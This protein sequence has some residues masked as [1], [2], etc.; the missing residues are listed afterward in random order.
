MK[1]QLSDG[2]ELDIPENT[3]PRC[4]LDEDRTCDLVLA[5]IQ[6]YAKPSEIDMPVNWGCPV[7]H[8]V[9][10]V[11]IDNPDYVADDSDKAD[12]DGDG[13]PAGRCYRCDGRV[14]TVCTLNTKGYNDIPMILNGC[15]YCIEFYVGPYEGSNNMPIEVAVEAI[16]LKRRYGATTAGVLHMI[17]TYADIVLTKMLAN[18]IDLWIKQAASGIL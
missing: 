14:E 9:Q 10:V 18:V 3:C 12:D 17:D 4:K 13:V 7:C 15:K 5:E 11:I 8:H 16:E 1:I 2:T 6:P